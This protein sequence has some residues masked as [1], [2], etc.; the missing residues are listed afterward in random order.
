MVAMSGLILAQ[1]LVHNAIAVT[2]PAWVEVK[3]TSG[4][5]A[6]EMNIRMMIVM[7]GSL[8][9]L[10]FVVMVPAAAAYVAYMVTDGLLVPSVMFTVLIAAECLVATEILG[11]MLDRTDLHDVVVTE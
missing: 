6:M 10:P 11:R 9:V 8:L 3:V 5:A 7:Y 2:F 4:A 1:L